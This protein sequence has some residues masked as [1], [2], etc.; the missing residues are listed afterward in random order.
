MRHR[1]KAFQSALNTAHLLFSYLQISSDSTSVKSLRICKAKSAAVACHVTLTGWM[2]EGCNCAVATWGT[3]VRLCVLNTERPAIE[4][5][6]PTLGWGY[7]ES[8]EIP[9]KKAVDIKTTHR[10]LRSAANLGLT[11]VGPRPVPMCSSCTANAEICAKRS[12]ADGLRLYS[13]DSSWNSIR[14]NCM[15]YVYTV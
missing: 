4:R 2:Q 12:Y 1:L 11:T 3:Q 13:T 9:S 8:D 7:P 5:P 10:I 15:I 6:I 14:P